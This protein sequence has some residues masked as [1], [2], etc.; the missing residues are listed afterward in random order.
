[1]LNCK[2]FLVTGA[3]RKHVKRRTRFQQHRDASCHQ[4]PP[5]SP[6]RQGAEGNS[7]H[8]DRNIRGTCT[9]VCHRKNWVVQFKRGDFST[10][11]APR[12]GRPKTVTTPKIIDQIH[13]LILEDRRISAK[14][15]AEQLAISRE[16]FGSIIHE[17]LDMR[18]LSTKW[19]PK[20]LKADKKRQRCQSS[21]QLL[22]SFR[23]D[24]KDFLSR[25]VTMDETWL[26][27]YDPETK[28]HSM[29]WRA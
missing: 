6:A 5:P 15:I 8:S 2:S 29:E 13:E 16:W 25:L 4:A 28:Q 19:V 9:L 14:S 20:C 23:L 1:M 27:H 26:Y 7:R 18:K 11:D 3:E 17:D 12:P 24:P 21:E 10:C 22:E